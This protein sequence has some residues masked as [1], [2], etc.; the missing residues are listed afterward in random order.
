MSDI[1]P[2]VAAALRDRV[3]QELVDETNRLREELRQEKDRLVFRITGQNGTP[4]YHE[5]S[6]TIACTTGFN[7]G[8]DVHM[9]QIIDGSN[10]D[11]INGGVGVPWKTFTKDLEFRLGGVVLKDNRKTPI[12]VKDCKFNQ[13]YVHFVCEF[14]GPLLR[15]EWSVKSKPPPFDRW[16]YHGYTES[17]SE[18]ETEIRIFLNSFQGDV[19]IDHVDFESSIVNPMSDDDDDDSLELEMEMDEDSDD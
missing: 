11:R 13:E 5:Q 6:V 15:I 18:I 4:V 12:L 9:I 16:I 8:S 3:V 19:V 14:D 17:D 2:F 1:G 10:G 7:N